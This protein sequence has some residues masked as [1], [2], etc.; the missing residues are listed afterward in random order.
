MS[1]NSGED[2]PTTL[3]LE[4]QKTSL[5][6][7]G[8]H[9]ADLSFSERTVIEEAL[10][11]KQLDV[12]CATPTLASGV[13]FPVR[14]VVFDAF[15]RSWLNPP[16][17]SMEEYLNMSGRAGRLGMHDEGLVVLCPDSRVE[18]MKA[19]EF[20]IGDQQPIK[21][22]LL[23]GSLRKA[24]LN[25][26][27]SNIVKSFDDLNSF[28]E[29]TFWWLQH[30]EAD[31]DIVNRLPRRNS[32]AVEW[33]SKNKLVNI[34]GNTIKNTSLGVSVAESGL[35]PS[36][37]IMLLSVI[38]DNI[39]EF[40]GDQDGY[41]VPFI[42]A[43]FCSE[44]FDDENGRKFLPYAR[45][46]AEVHATQLINK[47]G[48]FIDRDYGPHP[49]K[50]TNATAAI[51]KWIEGISEKDLRRMFPSISYGYFQGLAADTA[52]IIDGIVRIARNPDSGINNIIATKLHVLNMRVRY[53]VPSSG[54]DIGLPP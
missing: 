49:E 8:F 52:W 37:A 11:N 20:I 51:T 54:I 28:F 44:E 53:G 43:I 12:V 19:E 9:T 46:K 24:V 18:R 2:Q 17:I 39:D 1:A 42:H 34:S 6:R 36:A 48:T 22:K 45:N 32:E 21:S 7:I 4:L 10:L 35:F 27:S 47:C 5:K 3:S 50:I 29:E 16:W 41:L 26:I 31:A 25:L 30:I 23:G 14:T 40:E 38:K 33:L 15:Q 13:N